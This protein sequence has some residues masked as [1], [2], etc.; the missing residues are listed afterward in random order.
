MAEGDSSP[1]ADRP[2]RSEHDYYRIRRVRAAA[3]TASINEYNRLVTWISGGA[4]GLS[5][6]FV[7]KLSPQIRPGSAWMLISGWALLGVALL[8]SLFSHYASSRVHSM[9]LRELDHFQTPPDQRRG[10][11]SAEAKRFDWWAASYGRATNVLTMASGLFLV[12][13][14]MFLAGFAYA[15]V[16][17][18]APESVVNRQA[19]PQP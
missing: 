17:S 11:W 13:G 18:D 3:Y 15:S 12:G 6:T 10:A 14:F 16:S 9:K 19:T 4:L 7:E 5:I 8:T 1:R 2:P